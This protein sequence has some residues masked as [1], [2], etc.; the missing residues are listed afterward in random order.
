M[1]VNVMY[2]YQ[3]QDESFDGPPAIQA[4]AR[5]I[6]QWF[7]G[8]GHRNVLIDVAN[9]YDLRDRWDFDRYI[10]NHAH[11]LVTQVAKLLRG[12]R[13]LIPVTA[14][15][16]GRMQFP[17]P[18]MTASDVILIHGNNRTIAQKKTRAAELASARKPVLMNEDDNG[19]ASTQANLKGDLASCDIFFGQAGG[20]GYMPWVQAQ[21]FPFRYLPSRGNVVRDQDPEAERDMAY[22]HAVLD[23]IA[24]L[25]LKNPP[26]PQ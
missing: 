6:T 18:I 11:E 24:S 19:R 5:N 1:F 8:K 3:G 23:H 22:F 10:P 26:H 2:F 25:T 4:A 20:W 15:S 17:E 12:R 13:S 7:V 16:D 21:R 9:E 14:S